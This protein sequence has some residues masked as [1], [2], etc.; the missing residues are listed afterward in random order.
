MVNWK[1]NR[2]N[3]KCA[4][5]FFTTVYSFTLTTEIWNFDLKKRLWQTL[6]AFRSNWYITSQMH[7]LNLS[8]VTFWMIFEKIIVWKRIA[9]RES[10]L[11]LNFERNLMK[12]NVS[13][14]DY[15]TIHTAKTRQNTKKIII[16]MQPWQR[17]CCSVCYN[18]LTL[19]L[20]EDESIRSKRVSS[21]CNSVF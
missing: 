4:C 15:K 11:I 12:F 1:R 19:H 21:L 18:I 17:I 9:Q 20:T 2:K 3:Y 16:E 6:N 10:H 13:T 7:R 8:N 14:S 5:T